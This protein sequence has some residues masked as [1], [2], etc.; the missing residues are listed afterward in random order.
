MRLRRL[1][2]ASPSALLGALA[3]TIMPTL[4]FATCPIELAT[5][6]DHDKV[7]EINFTP[8]ADGSATITNRFRLLLPGSVVLDGFVQWT[9]GVARPYGTLQFNCPDGD[10][11]GEQYAACTVWQGVVY[12]VEESGTVDLLPA[13]A[14][15]APKRLI[16]SDLGASLAAFAKL[17]GRLPKIPSDVFQLNG[18][19]E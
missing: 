18:C 4:A 17:A 10:V 8:V 9:V 19:Q 12:S 3:G 7:A 11:T 15:P 2:T 13:Q 14:K 5:Y 1:F 6:A 16:L